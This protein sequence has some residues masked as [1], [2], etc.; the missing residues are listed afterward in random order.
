MSRL[1]FLLYISSIKLENMKAILKN[2]NLLVLL[3]TLAILAVGIFVMPMLVALGCKLLLFIFEQP[4]KALMISGS[5]TIGMIINELL[6]R[7]G[8]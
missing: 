1:T 7:Y 6:N 2:E 5:F 3:A 8:K 4:M